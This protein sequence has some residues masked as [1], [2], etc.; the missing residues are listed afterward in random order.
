MRVLPYP[1]TPPAPIPLAFIG[2]RVS[3]PFYARGYS[4]QKI[5]DARKARGSQDPAD[6]F[7]KTRIRYVFML[8]FN[9][10]DKVFYLRLRL[11][12][13]NFHEK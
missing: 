3:P 8:P 2:P 4:Q 6:I 1:P 9:C 12:L 5:P 13:I 7:L 10:H 11:F